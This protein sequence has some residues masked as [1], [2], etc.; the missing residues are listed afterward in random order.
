M[1]KTTAPLDAPKV[2]RIGRVQL[3]LNV[4]VQALVVVAIVAMVNY[5]S[6]RHYKRLDWSHSQKFKLEEQTKAILANLAKPVKAIVFFAGEGEAE[7]DCK[8]LLR[9]Y[10]FASKGK[11]TVEEVSPYLNLTRAKELAA[12]YKFGGNEN[13]V[14][15]DYD[16]KHKFINSSDMAEFEQLDQMATAMGRR[17][18]MLAFKG[19]QQ[20]RKSVV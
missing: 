10:E 8:L 15:L 13:I 1:E 18:Q 16:G 20:D 7:G 14:I 9:E 6:F 19:E 5:L 11:I 17:P 2:L 3:T 12:K 4:I